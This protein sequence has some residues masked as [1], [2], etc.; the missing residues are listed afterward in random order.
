MKWWW[1]FFNHHYIIFSYSPWF[2]F[3]SFSL[4]H[5]F[6]RL[7][8]ALHRHFLFSS[9]L[10]HHHNTTHHHHH[11]HTHTHTPCEEGE[12]V[13]RVAAVCTHHIIIIIIIITH[14][15]T[16]TPCEEGE[17]VRRVAAVCRDGR[18]G[19]PIEDIT[20]DGLGGHNTDGTDAGMGSV[21]E[22]S[23]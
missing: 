5:D 9:L 19:D 1:N 22:L 8:L 15:H 4:S 23:N 13:R 2:F 6:S 11:T 16:H 17:G 20:E 12:G 3:R 10:P 14:T 18:V 21:C 7:S